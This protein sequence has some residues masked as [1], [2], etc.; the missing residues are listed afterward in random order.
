VKK[1]NNWKNESMK[2]IMEIE[3]LE[4]KL[5]FDGDFKYIYNIEELK[6]FI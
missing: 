4:K 3:D 6:T 5:L 1:L 2:L